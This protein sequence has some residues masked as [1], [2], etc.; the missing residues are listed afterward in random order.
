MVERNNGR[1]PVNNE[2]LAMQRQWQERVYGGNPDL[3]GRLQKFQEESGE[4]L[5]IPFRMG[6]VDQ[7]NNPE[8]A[9][10][11]ELAG[12]VVDTIIAGLGV[13][14][15]LGYDFEQ[16]FL[17]KLGVMYDKYHPGRVEHHMSNGLSRHDAIETVKREWKGRQSP[18]GKASP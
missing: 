16:L 5:E 2:H 11:R 1:P 6:T 7:I 13:L 4:V 9:V 18:N 14:D 17:E 8:P 10:A 12:E 3:Y 15:V